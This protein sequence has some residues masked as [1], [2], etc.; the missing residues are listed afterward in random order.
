MPLKKY[1]KYKYKAV[2]PNITAEYLRKKIFEELAEKDMEDTDMKKVLDI[3]G[4]YNAA[5]RKSPPKKKYTRSRKDKQIESLKKDLEKLK[6][7]HLTLKRTKEKIKRDL[8]KEIRAL[9]KENR[10]LRIKLFRRD[11]RF[12]IMDLGDGDV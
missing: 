11:G 1:K 6:E 9:K 5:R 4:K 7:R 2:S 10:E 12:E 8:E 3:V